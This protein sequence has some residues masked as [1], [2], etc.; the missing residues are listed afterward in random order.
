MVASELARQVLGTLRDVEGVQGSFV[1]STRGELLARDLPAVLDD[2]LFAVVGPRI[3]RFHYAL[4]A[5]GEDLC[6]VVLR[7]AQH[8]LEV[9]P[10]ASGFVCVLCDVNTNAAALRMAM[11]LVARGLEPV[12]EGRTHA[13][14]ATLPAQLATGLDE[15]TPAPPTP[16]TTPGR[17][18]LLSPTSSARAPITYRGR[19]LA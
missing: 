2:G 4:T 9:R 17:S 10:G 16:A 13:A 19:R 6:Q 18:T 14:P 1:L 11:A 15:A 7:F 5:Q 8:R 12:L 3:L